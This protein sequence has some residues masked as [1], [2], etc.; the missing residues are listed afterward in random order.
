MMNVTS[1]DYSSAGLDATSGTSARG[2]PKGR[3]RSP[4]LHVND[5]DKD[6]R[7][8]VLLEGALR[9]PVHLGLPVVVGV[10]DLRLLDWL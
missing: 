9:A 2:L 6:L 4:R 7:Y 1:D 8:E 5:V 10:L 3:G